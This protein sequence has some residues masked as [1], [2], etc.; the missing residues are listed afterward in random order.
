MAGP[1]RIF[2]YKNGKRYLVNSLEPYLRKSIKLGMFMD[3]SRITKADVK[4][5]RWIGF[6]L[7]KGATSPDK[8][9]SVYAVPNQLKRG[10][11]YELVR[12][13]DRVDKFPLC[14]DEIKHI[15]GFG[16]F[17][18]WVFFANPNGGP[19]VLGIDFSLAARRTSGIANSMI[20]AIEVIKTAAKHGIPV[21][22]EVA[23]LNWRMC[24]DSAVKNFRYG[25]G[26]VTVKDWIERGGKLFT[27]RS[28]LCPRCGL[29]TLKDNQRFC[30]KCGCQPELFWNT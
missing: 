22:A 3:S 21:T 28:G 2:V 11:H 7:G 12:G 1:D 13:L 19:G 10:L 5:C 15:N 17:V 14:Y 27:R 29:E 6:G 18:R 9:I 24:E 23:L 20:R 8:N 16:G 30:F 25:F 26:L 4:E